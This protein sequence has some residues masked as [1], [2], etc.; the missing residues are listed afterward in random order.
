MIPS[1]H[2]PEKL[3]TREEAAAILRVK[4]ATLAAWVSRETVHLPFVKIGG[5]THY[6][7]R[8]IAALINRS[9]VAADEAAR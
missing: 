7:E 5:R 8:D 4:P 6:L 9:R 3:L 2:L 1:T